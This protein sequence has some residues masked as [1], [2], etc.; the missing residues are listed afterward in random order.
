MGVSSGTSQ[1][2]GQA[3]HAQGRPDVDGD[4]LSF[5]SKVEIPSKPASYDSLSFDGNGFNVNDVPRMGGSSLYELF[6]LDDIGGTQ[7]QKQARDR[8][9]ATLIFS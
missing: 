9:K 7:A 5:R 2:N 3:R 6:F 4:D 1:V 8:A